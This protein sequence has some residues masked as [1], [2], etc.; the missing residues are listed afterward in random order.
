MSPAEREEVP[1]RIQAGV[2]GVGLFSTS[3]FYIGSVII[4]LHVYTMNPSPL[5]FGLMFSVPHVLPL[6]LSIHGG[7][8]MDR[9]GARQVMLAITTLG[10][11]VPLLYPVAPS[12]WALMVLQMLLGL[13]ES[14][15]WLGA[16]TMIGQYMQGRTVYAGRLSAVIRISQLAAPPL[17]GIA[18]DL[19]GP[20]GAFTLM[21]LWASGAIFCALWL[22]A[23]PPGK[24]EHDA[25]SPRVQVRMRDLTPRLADYI[26]AFQLLRSPAVVLIVLLGA[27]MHVG[28]AMQGSFYVA[29]L[30]EMRITGTSI[31]LLSAAGAVG[32]ALFSLLT[33]HLMRYVGGLWIALL[34]IWAG[35]VL[36]CVT[37]LLGSYFLLQV[38]MFLRSGANGLAQPLII[39]LVLR[40]AGRANQGKAVGLRGTANRIASI[41]APLGMGVIAE[42]AGL[43]ASFYI[44]GIAISVMS[45]AVAM[46]LWSRPELG[47]AGED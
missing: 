17:A 20:W 1:W 3:I 24:G 10:A 18:W 11:V 16:Q 39:S 7:A 27:M 44:V 41:I 19:A 13:S 45:A 14:L 37:P 12:I 32:A 21:S 36:I 38:A 33:T 4:P 34:S 31:G 28:N 22:P 25:K 9:L 6:V 46:Y 42:I 40:G 30:T 43:E 35:L 8:M 26:T 2:Y 5:V 15:G 29:W 23:L 47:Q